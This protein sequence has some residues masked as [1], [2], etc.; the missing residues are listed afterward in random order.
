MESISRLTNLIL[1]FHENSSIEE[2]EFLEFI[3][4]IVKDI[5]SLQ[6]P[7]KTVLKWL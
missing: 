5:P 7:V 2:A 4:F 3:E 1:T 6:K